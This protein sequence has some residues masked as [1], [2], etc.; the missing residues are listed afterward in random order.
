MARIKNAVLDT[1]PLT[2]LGQIDSL[3]VFRVFQDILLSED[4]VR[5]LGDASRFP[6][7]CK[8][9]R[10]KGRAKDMSKLIMEEYG[11]G[12]GESTAIALA[13]QEGVSL[14]FTDDLE[15]REVARSYGLEPH[16]TLAIV[17]RAYRENIIGK[18]E[19]IACIDRLHRDSTLYLT[20]DIV[21]WA[22]S[23]IEKHDE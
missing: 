15:A 13:K 4:V 22:I 12:A 20:I 1:G 19:A 23:Q 2:H 21:H 6:A 16:G 3:K 11:L 14:V 9:S 5:E 18:R 10:L 7:N 8:V 17:T